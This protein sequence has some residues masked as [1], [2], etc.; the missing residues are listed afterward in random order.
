MQIVAEVLKSYPGITVSEVRGPCRDATLVRAR[1]EAIYE[2]RR[3][4]SFSLPQ[5]G[6]W[7]GGRDH[8]SILSAVRKI[9]KQ[10][11]EA[12]E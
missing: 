2:V 4:T 8:S 1:H 12:C 7:F 6:R 5:I 3:Q 11:Q 10:R 9:R